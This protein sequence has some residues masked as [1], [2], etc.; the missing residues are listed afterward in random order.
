M[1]GQAQAKEDF[2]GPPIL[3]LLSIRIFFLIVL[4]LV[5]AAPGCPEAAAIASIRSAAYV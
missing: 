5:S 1:K 4:W 2:S 3:I